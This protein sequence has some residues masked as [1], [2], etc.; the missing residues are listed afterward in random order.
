MC[1]LF[2]IRTELKV[3]V[4]LIKYQNGE[5]V[6]VKEDFIN[7]DGT[8]VVADD[9]E[10][11]KK[12]FSSILLNDHNIKPKQYTIDSVEYVRNVN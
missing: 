11:A 12:L 1:K 3:P 8:E 4:Q 9:E 7:F 2:K 10:S 6:V 5:R